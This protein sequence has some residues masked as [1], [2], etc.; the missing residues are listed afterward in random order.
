MFTA[1]TVPCVETSTALIKGLE[2]VCNDYLNSY[3][4]RAHAKCAEIIKEILRDLMQH[5]K[6]E[7]EAFKVACIQFVVQALSVY[8]KS[9]SSQSF[10]KALDELCNRHPRELN[11]DELK[12]AGMKYPAASLQAYLAKQDP[13][14][15]WIQQGQ[16]KEFKQRFEIYS[17]YNRRA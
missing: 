15:Q 11:A 17:A 1:K 10:L 9:Q 14:C 4:P 5:Y 13:A 3:F 6:G 7:C 12:I 2:K 16:I 8:L